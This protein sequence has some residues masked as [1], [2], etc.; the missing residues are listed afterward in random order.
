M[1]DTKLVEEGLVATFDKLCFVNG[2]ETALFLGNTSSNMEEIGF[3]ELN[4]FGIAIAI[5]LYYRFGVRKDSPVVLLCPD[6]N[7]GAQLA[8]ML[9]CRRIGAVFVPIDKSWIGTSRIQQLLDETKASVGITVAEVD[10]DTNAQSLFNHELH[11]V[12]YLQPNGE[13]K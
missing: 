4:E 10:T 6:S 11:K 3:T 2:D 5:Q 7:A 9:A 1:M 12:L 8:S 13:R